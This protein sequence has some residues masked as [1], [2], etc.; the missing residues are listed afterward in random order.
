[1]PPKEII[2]FERL[3]KLM[4]GPLHL[5]D[6]IEKEINTEVN[7]AFQEGNP[8]KEMDTNVIDKISDQAGQSPGENSNVDPPAI[9]D[10]PT[11]EAKI[12]TKSQVQT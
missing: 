1:M 6:V 5:S 4:S 12:D 11:V 9:D 8:S 3:A 2:L 10:V 7:E